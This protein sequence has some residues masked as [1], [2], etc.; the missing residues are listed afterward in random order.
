MRSNRCTRRTALQRKMA[1]SVAIT[2]SV[3]HTG[4]VS[5]LTVQGKLMMGEA[6][7]E[8]RAAVDELLVAGNHRIVLN[9]SGVTHIDSAGLGALAMNF[10]NVR[11]AGGMLALAEAPKRVRDA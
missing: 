3:F 11:T 6:A 8:V 4:A 7:A 2:T 10:K 9:L 1:A 5:V